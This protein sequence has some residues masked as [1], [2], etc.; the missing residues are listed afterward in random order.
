[1]RSLIAGTRGSNLAM[2]QTRSVIDML[3]YNTEIKIIKTKGDVISDMALGN[4]QGKGFFTKELDDALLDGDIDFAVHSLKDLP[5]ELPRGLILA[6]IPKRESAKDV[7]V[8]PYSNLKKLPK[9]ARIGTSS[10]RRKA[11]LLHNRTDIK[12]VNLRGNVETRIKKLNKGFYDAIILAEAGLKRMG[13]K[14]Y[15]ILSPDYFIPAVS[16]GA[17]GIT[18]RKDDKFTRD[19]IFQVEDKA[20][21]I[22]CEAERAFLTTLQAGCQVPAGAYS[23]INLKKNE[24]I[25]SAFISS[26]DGKKFMRK[27]KSSF[28]KNSKDVSIQLA[29]ELLKLGGKEILEKIKRDEKG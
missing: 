6:G 21:R 1:M 22:T 2:V 11:E 3:E 5:I 25:I 18:T 29:N 13:Y 4:I 15:S 14:N 20:S 27:Q 8:G 19:I 7:I 23:E 9:N 12:V 16:Q 28:I 10:V 24:F 26:L 17:L